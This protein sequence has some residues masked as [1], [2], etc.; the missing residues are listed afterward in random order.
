MERKLLVTVSEDKRAHCAVHF[1][2][3]FI[4][5]K[6]EFKITLFYTAP[7]ATT[8][9]AKS[10]EEAREIKK[11][12]D[13][14][15]NRGRKA[16][17]SAFKELIRYGFSL[18]QVE[19]KLVVR[20]FGKAMDIIQEA[21][22]GLYDAVVLGRRGL[23]FIEELA[24][25]SVT[26][27]MLEQDVTIPMW[28]CKGHHKGGKDVLVCVDG[29]EPSLR[30]V[31]HIALILEDQPEHNIVLATVQQHGQGLGEIEEIFERSKDVI[32][33]LKIEPSRVKEKVLRGDNISGTILDEIHSSN[34]AM[35][36]TGRSGK[37]RGLFERL[38]IGSVS[39][40]IFKKAQGLAVCIC[41]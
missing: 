10:A 4:K 13:F 25:E 2:G 16:L 41:R 12:E 9:L 35:V 33:G 14:Y 24:D 18:E 19:E 1:L 26:K 22:K 40:E 15:L 20:R 36:A 11:L 28:I 37:G 30:T 3:G 21:E 8:D 38:F 39:Y 6:E 17:D 23:S 32:E 29:S 7:R 31:E 27:A 34:Y 5:R